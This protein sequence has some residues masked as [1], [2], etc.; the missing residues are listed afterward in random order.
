MIT[1]IARILRPAGAAAP[2]P[3][4]KYSNGA[5]TKRNEYPERVRG[6]LSREQ[7]GKLCILARQAFDAIY[8]R[9]PENTAELDEFR[10]CQVALAVNKPGLR[11]CVNDDYRPLQAWFLDL[12]GKQG[13]ARNAELAQAAE[14]RKLA[15]YKLTE[16]LTERKLPLAYVVPICRKKYKCELHEATAKQLWKLFFDVRRGGQRK[17]RQSDNCPF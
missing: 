7:K 8:G 12:A 1:G 9:A 10:H 4:S 15:L 17:A 16:A 14:P 2:L 6:A 3:E 13:A 11:A 5:R